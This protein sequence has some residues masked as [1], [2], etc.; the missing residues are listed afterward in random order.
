MADAALRA[1]NIMRFFHRPLDFI[2]ID[3]IPI[4]ASFA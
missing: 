1:K 2:P 3:Y 4:T